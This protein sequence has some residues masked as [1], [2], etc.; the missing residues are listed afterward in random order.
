MPSMSFSRMSHRVMSK[1][2]GARRSVSSASSA[3]STAQTSSTLW[4]SKRVIM[5]MRWNSS[6]SITSTRGEFKAVWIGEPGVVVSFLSKSRH[7]LEDPREL[8]A[9][10]LPHGVVDM[11]P[12]LR[13]QPGK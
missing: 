4:A 3:F 10:R 8:L 9:Q 12:W 1:L 13:H 5:A 6:S 7:L 11:S 2:P